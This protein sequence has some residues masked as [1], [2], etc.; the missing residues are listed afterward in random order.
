M[1]NLI[2]SPLTWLVVAEFVVVGALV[3]LAWSVVGAAGRPAL[4]SPALQLPETTPGP[5]SPL[6]DIAGVAR[7]G[8]RGP[9]PGLNLESAFW[10]VRLA[11]LNR[12]QVILEQLE[13][14]IV[15]TAIEALKRYLET[16]VLPAIQRAEHAGG[17]LVP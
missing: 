5:S 14:R 11:E 13:W 8:L 12:E 3:V 1:R 17:G 2:R 9:L 7:P 6:P 4:A 16:V 10:R 15:H